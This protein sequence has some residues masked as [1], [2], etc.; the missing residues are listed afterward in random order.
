M[1]ALHKKT[2]L[3]YIVAMLTLILV[4][5]VSLFLFKKMQDR[6]IEVRNVR[7]R[8]ASIEKYESIYVE[9]LR[10][11]E[12]INAS[13]SKIEKEV[14]A[15]DMIPLLLSNV[16]RF[17]KEVFVSA[18]IVSAQIIDQKGKPPYVSI[19][20]KAKGSLENLISFM[21]KIEQS[22]SE[23]SIEKISLVQGG[24]SEQQGIVSN[25]TTWELSATLFVLSYK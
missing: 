23:T 3:L 25:N 5:G 12:D 8:I 17:G 11:I 19:D 10:K 24:N 16:E 20:V 22:K 18:E 2:V 9:E 7:E 14:V 6:I 4:I 21:K 1:E 15:K 13:L